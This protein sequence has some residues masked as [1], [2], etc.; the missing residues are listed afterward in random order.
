M[1]ELV[2]ESVEGGVVSDCGH[3]IP[4]ERPDEITRQVLALT[5]PTAR[6]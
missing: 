6:Q 4:E 1:V 5:I 3:F 2:A